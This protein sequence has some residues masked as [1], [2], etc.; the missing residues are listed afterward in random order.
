MRKRQLKILK[1][2]LF[3]LQQVLT[4]NKFEAERISKIAIQNDSSSLKNAA[5]K[6]QNLGAEECHNHRIGTS[7]KIK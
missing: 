2:I 7:K 6:L 3:L 5:V 4:P 1:N